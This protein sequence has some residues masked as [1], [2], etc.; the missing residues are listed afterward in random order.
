MPVL[1]QE[2]CFNNNGKNKFVNKEIY[3]FER[4]A[5]WIHAYVVIAAA[6]CVGKGCVFEENQYIASSNVQLIWLIALSAQLSGTP[7]GSLIANCIRLLFHPTWIFKSS[8]HSPLPKVKTGDLT[9][10]EIWAPYVKFIGQVIKLLLSSS[11]SMW[12]DNWKHFRV[13][14][15]HEFSII[16]AANLL[17]AHVVTH[18]WYAISEFHLNWHYGM[19]TTAT[20]CSEHQLIQPYIYY[21][22]ERLIPLA[23]EVSF[24]FARH[25]IENQ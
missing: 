9:K 1:K 22:S 6:V 18:G 11:T 4:S 2:T 13:I 10:T 21:S 17:G 16:L 24:F 7:N 19:A 25:R 12:V 14:T 8:V 15:L 23:L 20:H 3:Y 5:L